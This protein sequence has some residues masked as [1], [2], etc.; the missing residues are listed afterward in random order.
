MKSIQTIIF[1]LTP[2]LFW[3]Q[4]SLT[5]FGISNK[6]T[7]NFDAATAAVP[8]GWSFFETGTNANT[9]FAIGTGSSNTGDTYFLGTGSEWCFGG[10]LSGN[11]NP[12]IGAYFTNNTGGSIS[13]ITISY[14]G[15]TWRVGV[16]NRSDRIEF[17]YSLNATAVNNGTWVPVTALDYS[18][19]GQASTASGSQL[20]SSVIASTISGLNIANGASFFIRW[21]DFNASGA[22]DAMGVDD[23]EIYVHAC[24]DITLPSSSVTGN[25]EQCVDNG[26]T[27]YGTTTD[28]Y[29]AVFKNGNTVNLT[30]DVHLGTFSTP[31]SSNG[32]N[33]QHQ[34]FLMN[35]LW[36]VT[37]NSGS[38]S[39][40]NPVKVRFYYNPSELTAAQSARNSAYAALT[41]TSSVTNG[42]SV[43][44]FKTLTVPM[45]ATF[46]SGI[47][48]NT[49]PSPVIKF[50]AA[51][52]TATIGISNNGIT[53][54]ELEGITSFSG[55]GG[56]FSFGA[57]NGV[58][59]NALPVTWVG[60]E[61]KKTEAGIVVD[62]Q[63]G[64]EH[65]SD[66]FVVETSQNG[67]DF[68]PIGK[69]IPAARYSQT[70]QFYQTT[71]PDQAE[72]I[73]FRIKQIDQDGGFTYSET[74]Q[75]EQFIDRSPHITLNPTKIS[76]NE[77]MVLTCN[78]LAGESVQMQIVDILGRVV[79][80][81]NIVVKDIETTK[82]IPL[83]TINLGTYRALLNSLKYHKSIRFTVE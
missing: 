69:P 23:F 39:S 54:I 81:N 12:T 8:A 80:Q 70:L 44:W 50:N 51:P 17:G 33:L 24:A 30:A 28:R 59:S 35:R 18:N 38:I 46:V 26:W 34:L 21:T 36:D 62:W 58:G 74:I 31:M 27:Y 55:G 66:Y 32:A 75:I 56:G 25:S 2:I 67:E 40:G 78:N 13:S 53:Y 82:S 49:F 43:E 29:F 5:G 57:P 72:N 71:F 22:D 65:N 47:V 14:K 83:P 64:S 20:H 37:L 45:N 41:G 63:T 10:L 1:S 68:V 3:A 6:Y 9:S 7:Q 15:E 61:A 73:Y 60:I 48:G 4:V 19:P 79:F 52:N 16:A 42:A 11:L 77:E 76:I